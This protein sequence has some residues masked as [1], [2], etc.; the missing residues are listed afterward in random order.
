MKKLLSI[1]TLL[2]ALSGA[3]SAAPYYSAVPAGGDLT[4][5]DMQP[6]YSIEG[7]YSIA[8]NSG[9]PDMWGVRAG[10]SLYSN[11]GDSVRHQFG[12]N[13]AA[14]WGEEDYVFEDYTYTTEVFMMPVTFGYDLNLELTDNVLFYLNGKIGYAW[15]E[16]EDDWGSADGSGFTWSVGAGLKFQCSDAIYVKVGYEFG[17]TYFREGDLDG[18]YGAHTITVG[19]GCTF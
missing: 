3:A 5:N 8:A 10:L 13:L 7:L 14:Q 4:P 6:V 19:V 9:D 18:I 12:L 15:A 11:G 16:V 1:V 2:G 17:R